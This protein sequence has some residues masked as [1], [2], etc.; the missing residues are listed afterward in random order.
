MNAHCIF[1]IARRRPWKWQFILLMWNLTFVLLTDL[2]HNT[3]RQPPWETHVQVC[4]TGSVRMLFLDAASVWND[5]T[6]VRWSVTS[7]CFGT[8]KQEVNFYYGTHC[9]P[10]KTVLWNKLNTTYP[11]RGAAGSTQTSLR[12]AGTCCVIYNLKQRFGL[13]LLHH[14]FLSSLTFFFQFFVPDYHSVIPYVCLCTRLD[15]SA[16]R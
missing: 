13:E 16:F 15:M 11:G 5:F 10:R 3:S 6:I 4:I 14:F 9:T 12:I 8:R 7:Y 2:L 1:D